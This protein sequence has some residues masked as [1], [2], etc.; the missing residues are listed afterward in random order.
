MSENEKAD[1]WREQIS[2]YRASGLTMKAWCA[3]HQIAFGQ[4]KY[5]IRKLGLQQRKRK[6]PT[7][8]WIEVTPESP[9]VSSLVV[10]VGTAAIDV[11]AGFDAA[12]LKQVV[13][14][15]GDHS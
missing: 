13:Q 9:A 7:T 12:L 2:Q 10:H 5:W 6:A 3:S 11:P 8:K 4:M 14:A 15:L 1:Y